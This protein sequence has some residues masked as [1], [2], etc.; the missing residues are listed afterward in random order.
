M[1]NETKFGRSYS[2][3]VATKSG[4]T[5]TTELPL[6]V[7]FDI[8]RNTFSSTNIASFRIYNL[9]PNHRNQIRKDPND[10]DDLR[11]LL[12]QAGYTP[13]NLPIAFQGTM[14]QAWSVREGT[15]FITQIEC[16]DGG[17]AFLNGLTQLSYAEGTPQR[18]IMESMISNLPNVALGAIGNLPVPNASGGSTN[19]SDTVTTKG[20]AYSG[21]PAN[22]LAE[23]SGG[24]F[25]VDNGKAY[26]LGNNEVIPGILNTI[27]AST[28]LLNT[29]IRE[30][31]I[32]TF[33]MLF[34]PRLLIGQLV[35][36]VSDTA[37]NFSGNY[38][39]VS[40]KHR[41]TI[42]GAVCGEAVTSVGLSYGPLGAFQTV[43]LA[44]KAVA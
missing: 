39:V 2:L 44:V 41:G 30:N 10:L 1:A 35:N 42:S 14:T 23:L 7:E 34:E 18:S 3:R 38:K 40:L 15:N 22:I 32:L 20:G 4:E 24:N 25:F 6:T 19:W 12:F 43:P 13:L 29:P 21:N 28:G 8:T 33:D 5:I 9:S 26:I 17:F 37:D 36:L 27:D 31:L 11:P 16:F